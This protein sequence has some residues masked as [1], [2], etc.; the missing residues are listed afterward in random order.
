MLVCGHH[1]AIVKRTS[2]G[3]QYLE[4]QSGVSN[5]WTPFETTRKSVE[6]TLKDRFD[7]RKT[8]KRKWGNVVNK[9]FFLAD[10]DS[11]QPTDEFREMMGFINTDK[12]K[13]KKGVGGF[14]K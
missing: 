2:L 13:Q 14:A 12:N 10:V 1:A 9:E 5:G 3:L 6:E 4:L 7:C 8:P 11:V